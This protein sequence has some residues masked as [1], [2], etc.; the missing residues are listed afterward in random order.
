MEKL[1]IIS[2][3]DGWHMSSIQEMVEAFK[4]FLEI[5]YPAHH[6]KFLERLTS[7]PEAARAEAVL[8]S[9]LRGQN[10][11]PTIAEDLSRG[12]T[13]FLCHQDGPVFFLE[14][15]SLGSSAAANASGISETIP[16]T[17]TANWYKTITKQLRRIVSSKAK[18][19]SAKEYPCI[20]AITTEHYSG[21]ALLGTLAA[22]A[23]LLSDTKLSFP[24]G[25][26]ESKVSAVT[27]LEESVFI[28]PKKDGEGLEA[29]RRNIAAILLVQIYPQESRIIGL[30]HPDPV[31]PFTIHFLPSIPFIRLQNWPPKN[32]KLNAE[33]I[34]ASPSVAQFY[35][36][37]I[38][39]TDDELK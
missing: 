29:C 37:P 17:S 15:T 5:K 1:H 38:Q 31:K 4:I 11:N 36:Q 16:K 22:E 20:L 30:L 32:N 14:V 12:G 13:D 34:I 35:H 6:K 19:L 8:F 24:I 25:A 2:R 23:M 28:R 21:E 18:Q 3:E 39:L 7:D 27:D 10:L 33:W 26:K 9:V